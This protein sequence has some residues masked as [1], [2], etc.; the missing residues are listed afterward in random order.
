MIGVITVD[1]AELPQVQRIERESSVL[2][3]VYYVGHTEPLYM[4]QIPGGIEL[5]V[6][7]SM[8]EDPNAVLILL[9]DLYPGFTFAQNRYQEHNIPLIYVMHHTQMRSDPYGDFDD[10]RPVLDDLVE[11]LSNHFPQAKD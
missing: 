6:P 8:R 5:M 2:T 9:T 11:A 1:I 10:N 7:T 3:L 4:E